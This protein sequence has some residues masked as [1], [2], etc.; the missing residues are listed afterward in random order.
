MAQHLGRALKP[1]ELVHHKGTQF[2]ST[3]IRNKSDNCIG[4]LELMACKEEHLPSMNVE[5]IVTGLQNRVIV[6]E[7][8]VARLQ[9]L[10]E[11]G[12]D[13]VPLNLESK[14]L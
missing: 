1:W 5:R 10:L 12:R 8:E 13:S 2:P 6:L 9:S 7:A 4:N 14:A 3:D 11:G